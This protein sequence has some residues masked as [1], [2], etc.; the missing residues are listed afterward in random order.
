MQS[1]EFAQVRA[2]YRTIASL[3]KGSIDSTAPKTFALI[4]ALSINKKENRHH[5]VEHIK[6]IDS[7]QRRLNRIEK[8]RVKY[9]S[10]QYVVG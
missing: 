10:T 3:H 4:K 8:G 6:N 9:C 2:T 5:I 7:L 1:P